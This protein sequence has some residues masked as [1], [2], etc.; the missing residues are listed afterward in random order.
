MHNETL[1]YMA[2]GKLP[3]AVVCISLG[4]I[5]ISL[6]TIFT[7]SASDLLVSL[8]CGIFVITLGLAS[9]GSCLVDRVR[10]KSSKFLK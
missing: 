5:T 1:V 6:F 7:V 8:G 3:F 2:E 9:L 10:K 4:I